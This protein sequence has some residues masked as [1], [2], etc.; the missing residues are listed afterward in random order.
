MRLLNALTLTLIAVPAMAQDTSGDAE[1]GKELFLNYACYSCHGYH[2]TGMT[3]LS[4]ETSGV[5][6]RE[7][8][9]LTY[10]RLRGELNPMNPS[11]SMPHYGEE[12]M[13]DEQA[14]DIYAYLI[15]LH[16]DPPALE[17][18]PAFVEILEDA[19]RR[20]DGDSDPE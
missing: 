5:L 2:G 7:D 6:S 8:V 16:D 4:K 17:E 10:L 20:T 14:R 19:E 12:V 1:Q 18:I 3:P 9:F 15:S 13:S 11:R